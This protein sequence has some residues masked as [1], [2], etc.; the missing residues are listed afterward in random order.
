MIL[1][2]ITSKGQ[3]TI[4]KSI[5]ELLHLFSGDKVEFVFN[6]KNEV[7]LKPITK[8]SSDVFASLSKYQKKS[9]VSIEEMNEGIKQRMRQSFS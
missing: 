7:V 5:R 9:P 2:T 3:I 8:K 1:S 4:P 6:D